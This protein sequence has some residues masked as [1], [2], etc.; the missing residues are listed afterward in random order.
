[1]VLERPLVD[2][3]GPCRPLPITAQA[4]SAL[5]LCVDDILVAETALQCVEVFPPGSS[6][7]TKS[8]RLADQLTLVSVVS[9]GFQLD[10]PN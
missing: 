8:A 1:M 4:W 6:S 10:Y 2:R 3:S 9:A 7:M 5:P